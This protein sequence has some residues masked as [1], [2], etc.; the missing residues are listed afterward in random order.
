MM[1]KVFDDHDI[2][3][4]E[5][6]RPNGSKQIFKFQATGMFLESKQ[7]IPEP[8]DFEAVL[9]MGHGDHVHRFEVNFSEDDHDHNHE[10]HHAHEVGD[11]LLGGDGTYQ[12][13]HERAH[14]EDVKRRFFGQKVTTGQIAM[15][16]LTGGWC[17]VRPW[18]RFW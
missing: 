16:G 13:A 9:S 1:A 15:F 10:H 7:K 14:A 3:S 5:T 8:H 17:R 4:I 2:A 11:D 12:D 18:S 6:L